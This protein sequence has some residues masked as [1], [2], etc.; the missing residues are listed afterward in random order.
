M[1][2]FFPVLELFD[3]LA[4]AEIKWQR[5]QSNREELD[6]YIEQT[7]QFNFNIVKV[8]YQTLK[9][10]HNTIWELE[11]ELKSGVEHNLELAEIGKRAIMIRN[12]NNKRIEIKNQIAKLLNC[13]VRETKQ[14]HLS[15]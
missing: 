2:Q 8:Q 3:R 13:N 7:N 4:I 12:H 1:S 11:A 6:W 5:T 14:D 9:E 15:Q 10:I